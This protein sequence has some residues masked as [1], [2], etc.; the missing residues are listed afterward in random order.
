MSEFIRRYWPLAASV[1]I[2]WLTILLLLIASLGQNQ[3]HLVY[4]LDDPYIHMAIAR[5]FSQHGVWGVTRYEFTSS[6]SSPLWTFA[7]SMA[8]RVFGSNEVSPFVMTLASATLAV[9][10]VYAVLAK[11]RLPPVYILLVLIGIVFL[12]PMPTLVFS[13]LEHLLHALITI[14]FVYVAA[15]SLASGSHSRWLWVLAPLV[16]LVRYEGLFLIAVVC[17]LFALRRRWITAATPGV[18]AVLPIAAYG[19]LSV[20]HGWF[21]LPNPVLLKGSLPDFHL[22]NVARYVERLMSAL[23]ENPHILFLLVAASIVFVLRLRE[24]RGLWEQRQIMTVMFAMT[25]LLHMLFAST[26]WYFRYEAYLVALGLLVIAAAGAEWALTSERRMN[27]RR[28]AALAALAAILVAPLLD[29]ITFALPT[30]PQATN[31]IYE[32]QYQMGLFIR[33]FYSGETIAAND[34]GAINYLADVRCIDV[35]GLGTLATAR[36]ILVQKGRLPESASDRSDVF[37]DVKIAILYA[38]SSPDLAARW[39]DVGQWTTPDNVVLGD[40]V[41]SFFAVDPSQTDR[42]IDHLKQ[43]AP[44]LPLDIVQAGVYTER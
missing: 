38:K 19:A 13:G 7:L 44:A 15:R 20:A 35:W 31:N 12:S 5:N 3:G 39:T 42:L 8:Y 2:L 37:K 34:I 33:Q 1:S 41:V 14:L 36:N 43:F 26:G 30:T 22:S 25:S 6:S 24:R 10:A 28:A 27:G 21:W 11:D 29:R 17:F 32:Q 23:I 9:L 18:V 40:D 16:P 4:T